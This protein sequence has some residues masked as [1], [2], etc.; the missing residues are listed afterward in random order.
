MS[1]EWR[2]GTLWA[3]HWVV[4]TLCWPNSRGRVSCAKEWGRQKKSLSRWCPPT[5]QP[6]WVP[7]ATSSRV[8]VT[9]TNPDLH[10]TAWRTKN[11]R[12]ARYRFGAA[13][14]DSRAALLS[15]IVGF[16]R[17]HVASTPLHTHLAIDGGLVGQL[18][19][20]CART[21]GGALTVGLP[22][23][24]CGCCRREGR[25]IKGTRLR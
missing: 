2:L 24:A 23:M 25:S 22:R 21:V 13:N 5:Y 16:I 8:E 4:V 19:L 12:R 6:E 9:H 17:W 1:V 10:Q 7:L 18:V 11:A 3:A 14:K 20:Q 15:T